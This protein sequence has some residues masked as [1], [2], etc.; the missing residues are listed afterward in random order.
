MLILLNMSL[1]KNL[2]LGIAVI[3]I[4]T[5]QAFLNTRIRD[6]DTAWVEPPREGEMRWNPQLFRALVMNQSAAAT[7]WLWMR[8]CQDPAY[9][10]VKQGEHP[11][12]Y[13]DLDLASELDPAFYDLYYYG[14]GLLTVVRNDNPGAL[15]ILGKGEKFRKNDLPGFSEEFKKRYW[16]EAWTV[17]ML[18][19][20]IYM[21]EINDINKAADILSE[22]AKIERAPAHL[23]LLAKRMGT[24]EG[25]VEVGMRM[26]DTFIERTADEAVKE[27]FLLKKKAL[28]LTKYMYG[29]NKAYVEFVHSYGKGKA[30]SGPG[31]W[32]A[33]I[34]RYQG[35][36][37]DPFG[38][39][40]SVDGSGKV[41]TSTPFERVFGLDY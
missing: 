24:F 18:L 29:I 10:W 38:G 12:A 15:E 31:L 3:L 2:A 4:I 40:L 1:W 13:Y 6:L 32:S 21:F 11:P 30:V 28:V 19:A 26:L 7:D 37:R 5:A 27:K 16:K 39:E 35:A 22:V 8:A 41:V 20:Y 25:R 23:G 34:S 9:A 17:P 36:I 14:G 33:F